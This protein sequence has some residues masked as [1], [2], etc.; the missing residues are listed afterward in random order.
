MSKTTAWTTEANSFYITDDTEKELLKNSIINSYLDSDT[1]FFL[2]GAKG[3]GKTL[4]L[5]FKSYKYRK[6]SHD[7]VS[8]DTTLELTENLELRTKTFSAKDLEKFQ[9]ASTW[10]VIWELAIWTTIFRINRLLIN[11]ELVKIVG[12]YHSFSN[13]VVSLLNNRSKINSYKEFIL[14]FIE[15]QKEVQSSV[16]LFI[17]DV[18]QSIEDV[19]FESNMDRTNENY[20]K[21]WIN[22]QIGIM[23][24]ISHI[25]RKN[26]HIKIFVTIRSE[27]WRFYE[28]YGKE[29]LVEHVAELEY[30]KN[31][32]KEIFEKNIK[33]MN[34]N[35]YI[36]PNDKD[37]IV[38]FIGLEKIIHSVISN[39]DDPKKPV[40]ESV[41]NY[42]YRHTFGRPR[43][44][45]SIG[46][47]IHTLV[48]KSEYKE[49]IKND[50]E[51]AIQYIR[52]KVREKSSE[53]FKNYCREM[54]PNFD[55]SE[56][57]NFSELIKSNII[58]NK[59]IGESLLLIISK[60]CKLGFVGYTFTKDKEGN[61]IQKFEPP[62]KYNY[63]DKYSLPRNINYFLIH[64]CL[65]TSMLQSAT[66]DQYFNKTNIIGND[67]SFVI[68]KSIEVY[69]LQ[70]YI[71]NINGIRGYSQRKNLHDY[72]LTE[73]YESY[74]SDEPNCKEYKSKDKKCVRILI[75]LSRMCYAYKL[76]NQFKDDIE[77]YEREFQK[78]EYLL[79]QVFVTYAWQ[80]KLKSP[81]DSNLIIKLIGRIITIGCY[82]ILDINLNSIHHFLIK[83][84]MIFNKDKIL[85]KVDEKSVF[86][87]L[88]RSFYINGFSKDEPKYSYKNQNHKDV[89]KNIFNNLS[90]FEQDS[91]RRFRDSALE[92]IKSADWFAD[93]KHKE[94]LIINVLE[95]IWKPS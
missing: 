83:G 24:A 59:V 21:I 67:Y 87:Y 40:E 15:R 11:D 66:F 82:L 51:S 45:V 68:P 53:L 65:D 7:F 28:K 32:I 33:M 37:E 35:D 50:T 14:E 1:K 29:N 6:K 85:P 92:E 89:K 55:E 41:F 2:V 88:D 64:P 48:T 95:K 74:F 38:K 49:K 27:A 16:S 30:T 26:H 5:R 9:D 4:L 58:A 76:K 84:I 73:Y 70:D 25:F 13:I 54:I 69:S 80:I 71:P 46:Q 10:M 8:N 81:S 61:L 17:D 93:E 63:I 36:K 39:P 75:L 77:F 56:F 12:K 44:I 22:A 34:P 78:N 23:N 43:E 52:G 91:I 86:D 57:N 19:L 90:K 47:A 72:G 79:K 60:Y 42:L 94:W 62:A 20:I 31:E 18:D 3:L